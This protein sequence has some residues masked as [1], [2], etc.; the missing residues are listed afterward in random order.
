L[1]SAPADIGQGR[2]AHG[3]S[4]VRLSSVVPIGIIVV[5]AIVCV[6]VAVLGSAQRA[7]QVA[8]NTERQLFTRALSNHA[9]RVLREADGVATTEAAYRHIR[10]DFD[11]DWVQVYIGQRLQM[12]FD[13]DF[14]LVADPS[15]R[16]VY[17]SFGSRSVDPNWFN[18]VQPDLKPI[19]DQVRERGAPGAGSIKPGAMSLADARSE[20]SPRGDRA[21]R[22][23]SF[24]GR[25]A[26]VAAVPV[27]APW[28]DAKA[29][30]K[31][32]VVLSVKFVDDSVLAEIASRLQLHN[33]R[34][35]AEGSVAAMVFVQSPHVL[36]PVEVSHT[37]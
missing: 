32:P 15:D 5:V 17:A 9:E 20:K 26:I 31:A 19:L 22:V 7:D 2:K 23:Q 29:D 10:V 1:A 14:V 21:V 18:S 35:V 37:W 4:H 33:L 36:L 27:A 11:A 34:T 8:L 25:P 28:D 30:S 24:L 13:H 16:F 6:V 12:F 3:W